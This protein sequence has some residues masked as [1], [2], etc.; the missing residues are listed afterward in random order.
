MY[1][2]ELIR[3]KDD[4]ELPDIKVP[5]FVLKFL[6]SLKEKGRAYGTYVRYG[7]YIEGFL[8]WIKKE[9]E[10]NVTFEV[11]KALTREDYQA[12]YHMLLTKHHYTIDSLKR[13]ESVFM[14]LYRHYI[15][16]G[17]SEIVSPSITL[18]EAQSIQNCFK[19]DDFVLE[20]DFK[21]LITVMK[22]NIG[23]TEHQLKGRKLL[24][25]RNVSIAILFYKYGLT[26]K[27]LI[28]LTMMDVQL[29]RYKGINVKGKNKTRYIPLD[30]EDGILMVDYLRDIPKPV[31]PKYHSDDP[32]FVAFDYQRLTYRWVYDNND[33]I[34]NGH[35]KD[36]SRLAVQKMILQEV[37]R[38]G[39]SN[40]GINSQSMRNTAIL[41]AIQEGKG[42]KKIMEYFGFKTSI[43]LRRYK[44]YNRY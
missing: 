28:S 4:L 23:L 18:I 27:E 33:R 41:K 1:T 42:E 30:K 6:N 17:T 3:L 40:K 34:D 12:Y 44:E 2:L 9:K 15:S 20:K 16:L 10:T 14:Q 43:T 11:W 5:M 7:Y 13:V 25:N 21:R 24:I 35:P 39:L 36:L 26:M 29:G 31:R 22:S 32:F 8:D 19:P 38:A 37:R